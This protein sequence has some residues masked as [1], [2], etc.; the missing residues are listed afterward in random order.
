M[1]VYICNGIEIL[2]LQFSSVFAGNETGRG[3]EA[4]E[5]I[6]KKG[7]FEGPISTSNNWIGMTVVS[8]EPFFVVVYLD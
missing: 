6:R 5:K 7:E 1:Y 2:I 8:F 4:V 3:I